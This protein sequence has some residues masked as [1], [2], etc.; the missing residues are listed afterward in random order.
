[1]DSTAKL[2]SGILRGSIFQMGHFEQCITAKAPFL[3][4]Y[5]LATITAN[6]PKPNKSRDRF[7]LDYVP[8][9]SIFQRLYKYDDASQQSRNVIKIGWCIPASCSI[10]NLEEYLNDYLNKVD[11]SIKHKNI[12][13]TSKFSEEF[14]QTVIESQYFD[15][16][17]ISF[18][19]FGG[20][21]SVNGN[22][23]YYL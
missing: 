1:W 20:R 19:F 16:V 8:Y 3:T 9:D 22:C 13:Y 14:C 10:L 6:I 12:T 15:K 23:G 11:N 18:C 2:S 4:Q 7:S 5:C 21:I 17:D